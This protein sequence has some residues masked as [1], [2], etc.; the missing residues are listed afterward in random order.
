[1]D[2]IIEEYFNDMIIY[3]YQL[4][5]LGQAI[6][7]DRMIRLCYIQFQQQDDFTNGCN[8]WNDVAPMILTWDYFQSYFIKEVIKLDIANLEEKST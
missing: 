4:A 3:C 1:M 2:S 8:K 7:T 6:T 5:I